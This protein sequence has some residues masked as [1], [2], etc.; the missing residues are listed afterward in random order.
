MAKL[1][2][3][4]LAVASLAANCQGTGPMPTPVMDAGTMSDARRLWDGLP[5]PPDYDPPDGSVDGGGQNGMGSSS[6]SPPP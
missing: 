3:V 2:L 5:D 1:L 4:M 6:K